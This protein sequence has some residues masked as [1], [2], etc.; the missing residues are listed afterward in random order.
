MAEANEPIVVH[1]N[2]TAMNHQELAI[3]VENLIKQGYTFLFDTR[4][5][6]YWVKYANGKA[7]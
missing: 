2:S 1:F 6:K 4:G 3:S 5:W 7:A